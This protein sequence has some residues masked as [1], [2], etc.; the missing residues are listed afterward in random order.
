MKK[1]LLTITFLIGIFLVA[2]V[3]AETTNTTNI[4]QKDV[5][6]KVANFVKDVM[7]NEG[8]AKEKIKEVKQIDLNNLP[9]EVNIDNIDNT[10]L[11]MYQLDIGEEKPLYVIT[12]SDETFQKIEK[13]AKNKMFLDFGLNRDT[14]GPVFLETSTGVQTSKE[15][16]YVMM[17][18][19]SITGLSTNLEAI[20]GEG[21]IE[22]IIYKNQKEVGFRNLILIED[23]GVKKDY[24]IQ[25]ENTVT[26]EAGD[27]IS[28]YLNANG[29]LTITDITTLIELSVQ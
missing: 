23:L 7:K 5:S 3:L 9:Q 4:I 11:A 21:E 15:K 19:G 29:D 20:E 25:S 10:N 24:D 13:E 17:R 28:V 16:G 12:V 27:T 2:G 22:I 18:D 1:K 8:I 26:F 14:K 6:D